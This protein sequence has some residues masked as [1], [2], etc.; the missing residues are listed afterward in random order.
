MPGRH[1]LERSDGLR[2]ARRSTVRTS[3]HRRFAAKGVA[4]ILA[5]LRRIG[6][7]LDSPG[8]FEPEAA[9]FRIRRLRARAA[10]QLVA[11]ARARSVDLFE[12]GSLAFA[13]DDPL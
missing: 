10:R 6:V 3:I 8:C 1:G 4:T 12:T 7:D 5:T 13:T 2:A 9:P 11:P